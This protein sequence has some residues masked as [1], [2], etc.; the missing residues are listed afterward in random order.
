MVKLTFLPAVAGSTLRSLFSCV[1]TSP[2]LELLDDAAVVPLLLLSFLLLL[3]HAARSVGPAATAMPAPPSR[4][5]T[6]RREIPP[7][8]SSRGSVSSLIWFPLVESMNQWTCIGA[9]V[10]RMA[11]PNRNL[12]LRTPDED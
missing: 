2:E 8:S 11:P 9:S 6:S 7:L 10:L 4:F 5:S 12:G 3:P 1:A